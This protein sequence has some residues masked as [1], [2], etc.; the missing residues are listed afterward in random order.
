MRSETR[1][2]SRLFGE[3]VRS[4][5]KDG[6]AVRFRAHGRSM[7]PAVRDGDEVQVEPG[8]AARG[9]V[10]MV[11]TSEGLRVHRLMGRERT[12][13]DCCLEA[14]STGEIIGRI[15]RV[16]GRPVSRQRI[17]SRVRRWMARWR[18]RF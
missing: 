16:K 15:S 5:L 8:V 3:A 10:A 6:I 13:G 17:G 1:R 7:F 18:G 12:Q 2:D 14:D 9:E 4:L 11:E